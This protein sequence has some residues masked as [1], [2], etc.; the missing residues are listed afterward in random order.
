MKYNRILLSKRYIL[1]KD[2]KTLWS[3]R[4][5]V[6]RL[7]ATAFQYYA[8]YYE[9]QFKNST[10]KWHNTTNNLIYGN[11]FVPK[12]DQ[13]LVDTVFIIYWLYIVVYLRVYIDIDNNN[14]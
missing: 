10:Q 7:F 6:E 1:N 4:T 14:G 11:T 8:I 9:Y 3:Q 2:C 12:T 13:S 5:E